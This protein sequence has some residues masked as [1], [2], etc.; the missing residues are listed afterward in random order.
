MDEHDQREESLSIHSVTKEHTFSQ[1]ARHRSH[2]TWIDIIIIIMIMII[3]IT[4]Y[5][6]NYN[7]YYYYL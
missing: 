5:Y 2:A 4:Y 6:Y 7:Y 1:P 3:P